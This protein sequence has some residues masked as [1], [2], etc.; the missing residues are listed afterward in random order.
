MSST[1]K[2]FFWQ[3]MPIF[4][5]ICVAASLMA[6]FGVLDAMSQILGPVMGLFNLPSESALAV[7]L[8]SIRKDGIFLFAAEDGLAF[9]MTSAQTLTA[10]YLAGV[11][12]PCLVTALTIAK[13]SSWKQTSVL[14]ARQAAY[15][16][17]FSLVLAWGGRYFL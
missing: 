16:I 17:L 6:K 12:L 7:V 13:E 10:V 2:Q 11:L 9:P 3:A 8:S 5:L 4:V 14:L 15:A 1:L